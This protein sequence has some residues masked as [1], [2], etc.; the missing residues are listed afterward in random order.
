MIRA[1]ADATVPARPATVFASVVDLDNADWLPAVRRLRRL[2]AEK[3][4]GAR[5]AVEVGVL[6]RHLSGVLVCQELDPPRRA[7]YVL[8]DGID[9]SIML[10][11]V[12]VSGG[13]RLTV[14][15]R[16]SLGIGLG[17]AA[18][19]RASAGAARREVARAVEQLAARFVRSDKA[20][21]GA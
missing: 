15:A 19:E 6:G 16:Y 21:A 20:K 11:V 8:E 2:G 13:S 7:L 3:G 12:A 4:V 5:Y 1:R 17:G 9:L 18:L 10:D 14:E